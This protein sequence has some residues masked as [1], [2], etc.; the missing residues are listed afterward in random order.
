MSDFI[1]L[2]LCCMLT[3]PLL[4]REK[5]YA[6]ADG[7]RFRVE[8]VLKNLEI[9]WSIVFDN[10]GV[11]YFTERPG[12][13]QMLAKGSST[14][15]L[16]AK[17]DEVRHR[18]E[19][20]LMGLA[21]HPEFSSNGLL[22]LSYTF[23]FRNNLSNRVVRFR[24]VDGK[25]VDRKEILSYLPGAAVHNGCRLKFGPDGKL[26]VTTGDA[27]E[28]SI[29]QDLGTLGGKILRLN[30]DGTIPADNPDPKSP[31]YAFGVRNPQ[32][33]DWHPTAGLL[34]ETEHGPSGFDGPGG[35][36]EV[37]II[38]AGKNYGWPI[39]HHQEKRAG[40]ESPLLEYTPAVAPADGMFYRGNVIPRFQNNYFF[41]GLRG[42]RI[43]R[44]VLDDK[45]PRRVLKEEPLVLG[46]FRR[47]REVAEGPDGF[48]YFSTSNR[49]GR[50][51]P[52]DG[53]DKI[54]RIV[55]VR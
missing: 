6:T 34:F 14:P 45:N 8:T 32:G 30:D 42:E 13:L 43:Q 16:I 31:V 38:E 33:L 36:D 35:G 1:L 20:G 53:D 23:D 54:L 11:M 7:V 46:E 26:Y 44:I 3:A 49:D 10:T 24:L 21:L 55:P 2:S 4:Q 29:A 39:I 50:A 19:G 48:I 40:M 37:N 28:R 27:A 5:T 9:P 17:V 15:V 52:F 22:Y 12:R 18:G 41:G 51:T 25:L 47:I